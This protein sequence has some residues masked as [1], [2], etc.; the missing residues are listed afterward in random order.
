MKMEAVDVRESAGRLLYHPIFRSSGKKLMAKGHLLSE[1]DVRVLDAEGLDRIWVAELELGEVG[2]DYAASVIAGEVGCGSLEIRLVAGGRA[3]LVTT[4]NCCVLVDDML[5]R[6]VNQT[7]CLAVAT[8]PNFAFA[9]AW[10]RVATV[11]TTPF[12]VPQQ[13]MEA[14]RSFLRE[15]GPLLQGRP[16]RHPVVAVL[17]CD[18]LQGERARQLFE[19][20]MR[21][22]LDRDG[23]GVTFVLTAPEEEGALARALEHLLRHK[24]TIVLIASTTAPAGPSDAVG[25]AMERIGCKIERF[26]APVEPG[27]LLL[28]AYA[29]DVAVLSAP[30]CFRSPKSNVVDLLLPPLLA[31]YRVTAA[32]VA[33]LGHGGLLQ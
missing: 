27:N 26:L 17:Y 5:L 1:E 21:T 33:S 13:E 31:R 30:G 14:M 8:S 4:E 11:K 16:I 24:P 32:E 29:G 3:N 15:R 10:Q 2:E 23:T 7:G 22:R 9:A 19:G 25:R 6:Q 12:A 18:P 28:L 20:I